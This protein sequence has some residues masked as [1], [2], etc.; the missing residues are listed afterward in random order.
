MLSESVE[1]QFL[2]RIQSALARAGEIVASD[3]WQNATGGNRQ[4]AIKELELALSHSLR[5][6]LLQRGEGWLC[7]EDADDPARLGCDVVWVVDPVDGTIELISG[8]PEWSISVGL[9]IQG[10]PF[11][12]GVYNPSTHELFLGS[13]NLGATCNGKQV[14][15]SGRVT[16]DQAIVLA[17]RQE[18]ARGDWTCFENRNFTIRPTG[19]IAYKLALVS[20]GLA[21]ATWTLSPKHAWDVAAGVALVSASGRRVGL[22]GD[23]RFKFNEK[24]TLLPGLIA[25]AE[26]IWADVNSLLIASRYSS[27]GG[28]ERVFSAAKPK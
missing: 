24:E 20:A 13:W 5:N 6:A 11:A 9:V 15:P 28:P 22:P 10:V 8:L 4:G 27:E 26:G 25:S 16:L 1:R 2:D 21:D 19:S 18:F 7:E 17:S 14:R 23:V 3:P 12:G